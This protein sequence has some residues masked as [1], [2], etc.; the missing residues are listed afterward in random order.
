MRR[1]IGL[2]FVLS[3][4][5]MAIPRA[6]SAQPPAVPADIAAAAEESFVAKQT[7]TGGG[8]GGFVMSL[9]PLTADGP[10]A[11]L[12]SFDSHKDGFT[13]WL[14]TTRL[15]GD[16]A[17]EK[18]EAL[19]GKRPTD[20]Q[21]A[22]RAFAQQ[23]A[24]SHTLSANGASVLEDRRA[25]LCRRVLALELQLPV[26][27]SNILRATTGAFRSTRGLQPVGGVGVGRC[28]VPNLPKELALPAGL[29]LREA[30]NVIASSAE[31]FVWAAV[32]TGDSCDFGILFVGEPDGILCDGAIGGVKATDIP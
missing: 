13:R 8:R 1:D 16:Y 5:L 23:R 4:N 32:D 21:A 22:L 24:A 15:S 25:H 2:V 10:E 6:Q 26:V 7:V 28:V 30:L 27:E 18:L 3:L 31:A 29:T 19:Q 17:D 20:P 11:R 9:P 12:P 14:D